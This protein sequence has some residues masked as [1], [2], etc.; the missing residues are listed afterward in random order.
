MSCGLATPVQLYS[1]LVQNENQPVFEGS[2]YGY[3]CGS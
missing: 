1:V 3:T 2:D